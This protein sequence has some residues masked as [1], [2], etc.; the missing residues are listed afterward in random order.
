MGDLG[1]ELATYQGVYTQSEHQAKA[2]PLTQPVKLGR[3]APS[4]A[5]LLINAF[6]H[7]SPEV[8]P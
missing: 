7:A 6:S 5:M 4:P 8:A 1:M 2:E 3:A